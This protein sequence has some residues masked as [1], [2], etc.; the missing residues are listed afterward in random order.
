M[1]ENLRKS[2]IYFKKWDSYWKLTSANE[3]LTIRP[4]KCGRY[5]LDFKPRIIEGHYPHF[6]K[7][8]VPMWPK[9]SVGSNDS[10]YFYHY[11]TMCSY[12]LGQSDFYLTTG[13][14]TH[15]KKLVA[16]SDYI[17]KSGIVSEKGILLKESDE[18]GYH[19]GNI[20][21]MVQGEA[22]SVLC[23]AYEYSSDARYLDYALDLLPPFLFGVNDG[24]IIGKI[25]LIN[26][27]WYEEY[28]SQP[29]FHVLN[30]MIYSLWGLRDLYLTSENSSALEL[31]NTGAECVAK[32]LPL[33]DT[34]YWSYYWIPE[35]GKR[36]TASMMY[37]NLHI[38]QLYGLYNQTDII[39]FKEYA[40]KFVCYAENPLNRA[41][42]LKDIFKAKVR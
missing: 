35:N 33:F 39:E 38:C 14:I 9:D 22:M 27:N 28:I 6:D 37:H 5:P 26:A 4:G 13:D 23:R 30:G 21:A 2:L 25:S 36:Y 11:T 32:A 17:L 20:S 10:G 42:A 7:S 8:G 16:V 41:K 31:F 3:K 40:D 34:G 19:T 24:G 29:F 12:A 18:N 15:L 1:N